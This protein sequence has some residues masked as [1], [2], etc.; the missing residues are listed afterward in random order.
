M[1]AP[2]PSQSVKLEPKHTRL[3]KPL[4]LP[5][6][7]PSP[8]SVKLQL[9]C[10]RPPKPV[11]PP[12]QPPEDSF[13]PYKLRRAFRRAPWSFQIIEGVGW[14]WKPFLRKLE[15]VSPT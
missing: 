15:R 13:N 6:P 9:K 4:R 14:M 11:R 2:R 10:S 12:P 1:P 8:Q 5:S 3:P 7:P